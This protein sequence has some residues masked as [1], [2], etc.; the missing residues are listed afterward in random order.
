MENKCI[1]D[2]YSQ[3]CKS[4]FYVTEDKLCIFSANQSKTTAMHF[5]YYEDPVVS[6]GLTNS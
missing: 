6:L 2:C 3:N 5:L 1:T 4:L